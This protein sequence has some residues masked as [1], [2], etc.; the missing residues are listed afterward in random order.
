MDAPGGRAVGILLG[1]AAALVFWTAFLP[2]AERSVFGRV[3]ILDEVY[4]L[5]RAAELHGLF[6]PPDEPFFM[7]PLYPALIRLCGG[8]REVPADRVFAPADLRGI[9]VFQAAC[10][11]GIVVL[12]RWTAGKALP[13]GRMKEGSG[14]HRWRRQAVVWTPPLLFALYRPGAIYAVSIMLE[15]P[16]TLCVTAVAALATIAPQ[17]ERP[18]ARWIRSVRSPGLGALIG[19]AALLRGTALVLLPLVAVWSWRQPGGRARRA[20]ETGAM[21]LA[22]GLV[23]LPPVWHNSRAAGRL[24]PPTLNGGVNLYIGNGPHANGFYVAAVPGDWRRDP[25]GK[26]FLA[27]RLGLD[28]VSLPQADRIWT[29]EALKSIGQDPARVVALWA[30]KVWLHLQAWEI[31]QLTPLAAWSGQAVALRALM[32]PY[33]LIAGLGLF[34]LAAG[35][36]GPAGRRWATLL[37]ALVAVQSVF[38]VVSRY[39]LVLVPL[40]ALLAGV[41]VRR[42]LSG[43]WGRRQVLSLLVPAGLVSLLITPWG[44]SGVQDLWRGMAK[45]NEARRWAELG[46]AENQGPALERARGL[47]QEA[48]DQGAQGPAPWLGLGGVLKAQGR[49]AEAEQV[50]KEGSVTT[51]RDLDVDKAVISLLL[52]EGRAREALPWVQEVLARH[53]R[54]ADTLHNAAVLLAET[55]APAE[56][57]AAAEAL[58]AGHPGDARGYVDLGVLLARQGRREQA[59]EAFRR[60]LA[61]VPGHPDLER[62]LQ[63]LSGSADR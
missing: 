3:P 62:N 18:G 40:L 16:L 13:A 63:V 59:L 43:P 56:A 22:A 14:R 36:L 53:P 7:S 34:G 46:A 19:G 37:G 1:I 9:R 47:Y 2:Q 31:D 35:P 10:W 38:F 39:R 57:L 42:C 6:P 51:G 50:L 58:V 25:A 28:Q 49:T 21:L 41:G 29:Q 55:G 20:T 44:L 48:V 61:A 5:D 15:I 12:L 11:L 52:E 32:V 26:A 4:Y 54:D 33:G 8:A 24:L 30:K 60:G 27:E 23:L 45:A 17:E